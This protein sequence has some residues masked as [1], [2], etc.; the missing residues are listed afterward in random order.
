MKKIRIW[1]FVISFIIMMTTILLVPF[2]TITY[3][4][5]GFKLGYQTSQIS[6]LTIT[7]IAISTIYFLL[8]TIANAFERKAGK[9]IAVIAAIIGFGLITLLSIYSFTAIDTSGLARQEVKIFLSIPC[10]TLIAIDTGLN[11]FYSSVDL[12]QTTTV[13]QQV[14][15][16]EIN[17]DLGQQQMMNL[18]GVEIQDSTALKAR[19]QQMQGGLSKSYDEA[20]E[21]IEKTGAL[22]GIN[23]GSILKDDDEPVKITPITV[24]E[25]KHNSKSLNEENNNK[26]INDQEEYNPFIDDPLAKLYDSDYESLKSTSLSRSESSVAGGFKFLS[27][28]AQ[29]DEENSH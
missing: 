17:K 21:E 8:N 29:R 7:L 16:A 14:V 23:I 18:S 2:L 19:I 20:I 9:I 3:T 28:K 25:V 6:K 12:Q 27:K 10:I 5:T 22:N 26:K 15:S 1:K 24:E 13:V 11:I 4:S